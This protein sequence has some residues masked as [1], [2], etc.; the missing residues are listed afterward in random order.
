MRILFVHCNYPAQF[1]HLARHYGQQSQHQVVF[2]SKGHE[3]TA[4]ELEGV[5]RHSYSLQREPNSQ[6]CHPYLKRMESAVLHGQGALRKAL[7]L[8][9]QG[10]EPDVI[11]GHSGFGNT[12]FLKEVW[13]D[14]RFIGYFEWFYR[15]SGSDVGYGRNEVVSPDTSLRVHTYNAP[16]TMDL[17]LCDT[18][19]CPTQWQADQFPAALR[20][21]LQVVFD[22]IDTDVFRPHSQR[23]AGLQLEQLN[24]PPDVPLVTYVTRGFEP[25]RGWP[26]VAEGLSL[27]LQRNPHCQVL[28]VGSDEVA[29]GSARSDG[30]TWRQWGLEEFPLDPDRV[31]TLPA[32]Q[33]DEYLQ[34]LQA[35]WV[36]VYWSVPF[37]LSWS[38]MESL[39]TGC[40][41]VASAT[42]PVLEVIEDGHNGTAVDFHDTETM[43]AQIDRLLRDRNSAHKLGSEARRSIMEKGYSLNDCLPKQIQI[44]EDT[45]AS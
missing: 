40:C 13:P 45:F 18:A 2:L 4:R 24:I 36:H 30:K 3:W 32:L 43:A 41:V 38:L 23:P 10:F 16:I 9:Q 29:Y 14:A 6:L 31:H 33:Y 37:I 1:R 44:I 11:V 35:S 12:L 20:H 22:G 34:V 5:A 7:Q 28:L 25:Y 42:P 8:R 39:S 27:L 17:A 15:S 26:Q 19:L 21:R